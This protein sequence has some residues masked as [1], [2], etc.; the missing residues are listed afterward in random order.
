MSHIKLKKKREKIADGKI[1]FTFSNGN[2][3]LQ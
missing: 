2:L 1:D 3:L